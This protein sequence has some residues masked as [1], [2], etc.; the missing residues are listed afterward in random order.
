MTTMTF[1]G[2][3]EDALMKAMSE[4]ERI[5][6]FG[7]DVHSIRMN[8]FTKFGEMRVRPA[9]I[10]ESAFLGAAVTASMA[11]LRPIVEIMMIDFIAVAVDA[12]VNHAAKLE[13]FSGGRWKAPMVVRA[14]CGGGY[15]DG[16]QH[17]QTLWGWLAQVPG[18]KVV[19][20]SNPA[21]AGGLMLS[22]IQDEGPVIYMEHKLLADYWIDGLADGGRTNLEYDIPEAGACGEVPKTWEPIPIGEAN[23]LR[24]GDDLTMVSVGVSVHRC[25]EAAAQLADRGV[26]AGVIDLRSIAPL[27]TDAVCHAVERTGRLLVV[28]EDYKHFS[29]SGE[30]AAVVME[31]GIAAKFA[32]VALEDTIPFD[33]RREAQALP[34]VARILEAASALTEH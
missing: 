23:V 8:L 9:P 6:I 33:R 14:S 19:V 30:L 12:L 21:D 29:L 16:G 13:A 31:A 32:R 4:D 20:P 24:D 27:D 18:M 2:A 11:G 1:A 34:N 26:Q 10:S 28:D 22:A 7:E 17:E 15:G 25:L 3:I 5:V